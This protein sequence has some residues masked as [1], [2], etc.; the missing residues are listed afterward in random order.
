MSSLHRLTL[1][2]KLLSPV[3]KRL[4]EN[5]ISST[6]ENLASSFGWLRLALYTNVNNLGPVKQNYRSDKKQNALCD[7]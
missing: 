1:N 7:Q 5:S 3:P 2:T 4:R 6:A